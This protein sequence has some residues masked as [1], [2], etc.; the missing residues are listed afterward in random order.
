MDIDKFAER[1]FNGDDDIA[2]NNLDD[3]NRQVKEGD[4]FGYSYQSTINK[5]TAWGQANFSIDRLGF[6]VAA[7]VSNTNFFRTGD[8]RNG[9]FPDSSQGDSEK[10]DYLNYGVKGGLNY[11]IDGR[12][13]IYANG[14]CLLY[15]SPSPR[16]RTRSRMPSSA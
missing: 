1:D 3:P 15:T 5:T 11:G 7:N 12:N 9:R 13:Y 14:T 8:Y 16:D 4:R 2:Q 6:F 10:L